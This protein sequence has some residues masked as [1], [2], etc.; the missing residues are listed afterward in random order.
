MA[1]STELLKILLAKHY[2]GLSEAEI[3]AQLDVEKAKLAPAVPSNPALTTNPPASSVL[4][5]PTLDGATIQA[6]PSEVLGTVSELSPLN[7][8]PSAAPVNNRSISPIV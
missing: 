4:T 5:T 7:P 2:P 1:S 8:P 6:G 3:E